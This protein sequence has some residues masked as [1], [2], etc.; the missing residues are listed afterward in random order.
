[1]NY[2]LLFR[3]LAYIFF[4]LSG[5]LGASVGVGALY[6]EWTEQ[7]QAVRGFAISIGVALGCGILLRLLGRKADIR[8][9]KKEAFALIGI[10]WILASLLGSLP[11]ILILPD[12]HWADAVFESTS[13]FTTTGAS[14]FTGFETWPRSLLFWRCL[15]QWIGGL[16]VVVFFVAILGSLGASGKIL[17]SNESTSSSSE[18]EAGRFQSGVLQILYYYIGITVVC[19]LAFHFFELSWYDAVC[20]A[21]TTISTG[22]FS[23][24]SLSIEGFQN[25]ALEW[26]IIFFMILGATSFIL[27]IRLLQGDFR[28]IRRNNELHTFFVIL[29]IAT[30]LVAILRVEAT[31]RIEMPEQF[32]KAAFQ[33]TSIMTTTGYSTVDF[34][35]W[36]TPAKMI[37]LSLMLIGGC[38]SSTAGGVKVVRIL[39][40]FHVLRMSIERAFRPNVVRPIRV[41]G[42]ILTQ[43]Y[44]EN[45]IGFLNLMISI[46]LISVLGISL[47]EHQET[48][49]TAF[50]IVYCTLFN[51]GPGLDQV[52]PHANFG[53]LQPITKYL[54]SL[55]MVMGRL[56]LYAVLV[57]F[58]PSLWRK[59]S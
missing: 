10:S 55:L 5:A 46:L 38:T 34:A 26:C 41:N 2:R 1:M 36:Q 52:G 11:Y 49:A 48:V 16:G 56:E 40:L 39:I 32:R 19:I 31:G 25:P 18:I 43:E 23:T 37:L 4:A 42:K 27:M 50:S 8:F 6:Q 59:F 58:A 24:N 17:F 54:L 33:V 47:I 7:P 9:F 28:Q 35:A 44:R 14:V 45:S 57:L 12:I 3:L 30:L 51:I 22:G 13:G 29:V 20:H 53:F 15:T 21:F